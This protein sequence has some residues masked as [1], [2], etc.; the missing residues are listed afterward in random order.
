MK[1]KSVLLMLAVAG[2]VAAATDVLMVADELPAMEVLSK[3]LKTRIGSTTT[4]TTQDRI[5]GDLSVY[6]VVMVYIHKDIS[7]PAEKAFIAYAKGGGKLILL[8]HSISSGKRKNQEWFPFLNISL[9]TGDFAAGGYKYFDPA[10]FAVVNLAEKEF[11]TTN[12]VSYPEMVKYGD[13]ECPGFTLQ[14]TEVYLNHVFS[15]PRTVL[16][17]V[18]YE[19]KLSGRLYMQPTA[20]WYRRADK[21]SVMYFM[22]GHKASDFDV[23]VYAQILAN[24]VQFALK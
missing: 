20:G 5:P 6:P 3:Q 1:L 10:T 18:R 2:R 7:E 23:P 4:I 12:K 24:A 9:P 22:P 14:D 15:G 19:E 17:G 21:G 16:L 11:I 8:H 13:R